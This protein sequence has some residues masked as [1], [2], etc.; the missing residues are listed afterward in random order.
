MNYLLVI[1]CE[2]PLGKLRGLLLVILHVK[3]LSWDKLLKNHSS[4]EA[5]VDSDWYSDIINE[6]DALDESVERTDEITGLR[7]YS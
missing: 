2:E 7:V 4:F 3:H 1:I 6:V 5:L